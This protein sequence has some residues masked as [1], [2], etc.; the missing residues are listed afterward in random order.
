M[1]YKLKGLGEQ[2]SLPA[3]TNETACFIHM[4]SFVSRYLI[5]C[6]SQEWYLL[7]QELC[8]KCS[9]VLTELKPLEKLD[10]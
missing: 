9:S 2:S 5:A 7:D 6:E 3:P 10:T 8:G 1:L 4:N